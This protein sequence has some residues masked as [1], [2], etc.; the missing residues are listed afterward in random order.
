[1][2]K[3]QEKRI[4]IVGA[5]LCGLACA[6]KLKQYGLSPIVFEKSRDVGGRLATRKLK[7]GSEFDHGTQYIVSKGTEFQSYIENAIKTQNAAE[8]LFNSDQRDLK[9]FTRSVVGFPRMSAFVKPLTTNIEVRLNTYVEYIEQLDGAWSL[10]LGGDGLR[11]LVD[12]VMLAVPAPQVL[13]LIKS[14]SQLNKQLSTVSMD[15]CLTLIVGFGGTAFPKFETY[16]SEIGDIAWMARNNVKPGRNQGLDCWVVHANREWSTKYID[17]NHDEIT[18]LL[19]RRFA[20]FSHEKIP[21]I[22]Y[23]SAHKWRYA[24][25]KISLGQPFIK[26]S[27][28]SLFIGGDWCLGS[29]AENAYESGLAAASAILESL[30]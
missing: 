6:D 16:K 19:L 17:I 24:V 28:N 25:T 15:P 7:D 20:E 18:K 22:H 1:M 2:S 13:R 14:S 5:G 21:E 8:W 30:N 10:T 9:T 12:I 23:I 27:N 3:I 4:A 26:T 29:C 11:E